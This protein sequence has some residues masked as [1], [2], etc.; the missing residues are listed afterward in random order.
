[1]LTPLCEGRRTVP[2][3]LCKKR[4]AGEGGFGLTELKDD[5][6]SCMGTC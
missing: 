2:G 4:Q 6:S 5:D 1:M 3:L